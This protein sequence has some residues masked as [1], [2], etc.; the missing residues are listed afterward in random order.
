MDMPATLAP[1][2]RTT[3]RI[4]QCLVVAAICV[5]ALASAAGKDV[6]TLLKHMRDAYSG[7]KAAAFTTQTTLNSDQGNF[8]FTNDFLYKNPNMVRVII[9]GGPLKDAEITKV[10][11]GQKITASGSGA[12]TAPQVDY[13]P[14]EFGK[15][16]PANLESVSF[17]DWDRQ[18]NTA[19]GKNMAKSTFKIVKSEEWNGRKWTVLEETANEQKVWCRY[20]IDPSTFLIWRTVVKGLDD[21]KDMMDARITKL[22]TAASVEDSSFKIG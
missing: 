10:S 11:D 6:E 4:K 16:I 14:E 3:S 22:D 13:T 2:P 19:E 18:L 9:K 8:E 1:I 5:S 21:R 17:F 20:F 12:G 15:G 7:V